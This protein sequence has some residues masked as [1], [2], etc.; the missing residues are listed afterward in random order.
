MSNQV[1]VDGLS[2]V[3]WY[4][5]LVSGFLKVAGRIYLAV[6]LAFDADSGRRRYAL[7][8]LAVPEFPAPDLATIDRCFRTAVAEVARS[9]ADVYLTG[10]VPINGGC[11]NVVVASHE[12]VRLLSKIGFPSIDKAVLQQSHNVWL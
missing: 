9:L 8:P 5:G 3:E 4:D 11:L 2:V 7:L 1:T 12:E 10:D 6:L